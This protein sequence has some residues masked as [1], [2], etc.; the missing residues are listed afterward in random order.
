MSF[1]R[2]QLEAWRRWN[3]SVAMAERF[4]VESRER[5]AK[6]AAEGRSHVA[7]EENAHLYGSTAA[8]RPR[9]VSIGGVRL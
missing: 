8:E 1:I 2:N 7:L 3:E 6:F 5:I 4:H 9:I